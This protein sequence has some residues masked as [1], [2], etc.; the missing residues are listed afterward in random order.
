MDNKNTN[1]DVKIFED[2]LRMINGNVQ[3]NTNARK[4]F[5]DVV[6]GRR[7]PQTEWEIIYSCWEEAGNPEIK[8]WFRT[9]V[10]R[11][12]Y[13][14]FRANSSRPRTY[15]Q[16]GQLTPPLSAAE[17]KKTKVRKQSKAEIR[18]IHKLSGFDTIS[19]KFVQ[20]GSA[21]SK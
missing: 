7:K 19:A 13:A 1:K 20:G 16:G 15:Q 11:K 17:A 4:R 3:A 8:A 2:I 9:G 10:A 18:K 6:A 21:S 14:R 5:L 12:S